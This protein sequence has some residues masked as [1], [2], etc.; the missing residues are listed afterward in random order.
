MTALVVVIVYLLALLGVGVVSGLPSKE[1]SKDYFTASH[2]IG[3]VILLLSLFGSAMTAFALVGSTSEAR[4]EGIGVYG[5]MASWSGLIHAG[6]FYFVGIRLWAYGKRY[7]YLTQIQILRD[8]YES[9]LLGTLLFPVLTLLSVPYLL[10]GLLGSGSVM[11]AITKG[12]FPNTFPSTAGGVP[13][14]LTSLV[15]AGIIL[16]YIFNGGLRSAAWANSFQTIVFVT[17][18]LTA[19]AIIAHKLG[20]PVAASARVLEKHPDVLDRGEHIKPMHFMTYMFVPLSVGM[21]PHIFQHWLTA[22]N[23]KAFKLTVTAFPIAI[24]LVWLPCVLLGIWSTAAVMPGTDQLVVPLGA[25]PN[26]ELGIMINKLTTPGLSGFLGA[27]VLA[28]I[29]STLDS[30]FLA[31]GSMFTNDILVH[32]FGKDRFDERS[33]ML[34]AR[35]FVITIVAATYVLSLF[36]KQSVFKLGVWCFSGFASLFPIIFAAIYW[37]RVTKHGAIASLIVMTITWLV[38]FV[39]SGYGTKDETLLLGPAGVMPV[40]LIFI[41]SAATLVLVSLVT[42]PPSEATIRKFHIEE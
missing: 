35:V 9:D 33:K 24:L 2:S 10:T 32:H 30:Q 16:L 17:M 3:P 15:V 34:Y 20:G 28:A 6:V 11:V 19:V 22:K 5:L 23:A 13:E 7:G 38:L 26:S 18:G 12:A 8:R 27:G 42:K 31:L 37:K 36:W 4:H 29:M 14:W 41:A 21:F 39:K 40:T 1:S 25:K